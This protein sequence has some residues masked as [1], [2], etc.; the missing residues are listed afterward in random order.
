MKKLTC[1]MCGSTDLLKQEGVFVCQHCGCKYSVE[2]AKR[3]MIEG[4]VDVSGSTVKVDNSSF[5]QKYLENARRAKEKTDWEEVEKYYN[6]VEQNDPQNIEAIFYSSY[7]KVMLSLTDSD[8]FKRKQK[9]GVLE[10]S[11]SIVDDYYEV[12][13]AD[14]LMPLIKQMS[15]DIILMTNSSFVYN[16]QRS[17]CRAIV[18]QAMFSSA[19]REFAE[20]LENIIKKDE[21]EDLYKLLAVHYER[22][23]Q[24]NP[25]REGDR[26]DVRNDYRIRLEEINRKLKDTDPAYKSKEVPEVPRGCYVATAVYGSYDCP[27]VW[28]LR[29]FRDYTLATT[30]YGR[31]FIRTYYTIS[32]TLVK[33][34]GHTDW[35]KSMWRGKLDRMVSK[36]NDSG[37]EDTPYED[38]IW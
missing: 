35:F 13:K 5:V 38:K 8:G 2:D 25:W 36:L 28:T 22:L 7:A 4:V 18:T 6:M 16:Q 21:K 9:F 34:F 30:W 1:E 3:M 19:E 32:P 11:I 15:N 37:V 24:R 31:V 27:Q 26:G 12:Q 14:V 29:R 20:T 10:K 17:E 33:W 23:I